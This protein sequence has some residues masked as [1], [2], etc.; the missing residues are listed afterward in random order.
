MEWSP[1]RQMLHVFF[2]DLVPGEF[3]LRVS[4]MQCVDASWNSKPPCRLRSLREQG[5]SG[6][7]DICR[8][9]HLP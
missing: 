5:C 9:E 2:Q 8:T 1:K 3:P 7:I 4:G 6:E